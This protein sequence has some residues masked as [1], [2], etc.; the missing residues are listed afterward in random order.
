MQQKWMA[1]SD[2]HPWVKTLK[3]HNAEKIKILI[4]MAVDVYNDSRQL[5]LSANSWPS[6]THMIY[7]EMLD[8]VGGLVM[9]NVKEELENADCESKSEK[10]GAEG[11]LE[12]IKIL[13]VDLNID[14]LAK[15]KLTGLTTNGEN[16]NTDKN[17]GLWVR[18]KD[19]LQR[20][21]LSMWDVAHRSDLVLSDVE[22]N[23][24]EVKHWKKNLK[25]VW[26][27][28]YFMEKHWLL[29][30]KNSDASKMPKLKGFCGSRK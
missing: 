8:I 1:Q 9:K 17:S 6:R 29:I 27:N 16:A 10:R 2:K 30:T 4:E 25:A 5:T 28:L 7:A 20:D 3:S 13:F 11:L 12:A 23:I 14:K 15:E 24:I 21:I 26:K 18:M 19:Y 22:M